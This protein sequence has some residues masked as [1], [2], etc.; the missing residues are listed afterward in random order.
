VD[1]LLPAPVGS[2]RRARTITNRYVRIFHSPPGP[3]AMPYA[4][5][6]YIWWLWFRPAVSSS[7]LFQ[8]AGRPA[9][10]GWVGR[11]L[12]CRTDGLHSLAPCY[13]STARFLAL[14]RNANMQNK[15]HDRD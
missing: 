6:V 4:E 13:Y 3:E 12:R 10:S 1:C 15:T 14:T 11:V 8:T 5:R 2:G 9:A 7:S